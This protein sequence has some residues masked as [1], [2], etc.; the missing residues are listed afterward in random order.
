MKTI[1]VGGVAGGMSAATRLRRLDEHAEIVVF[2]RGSHVSYA[3]CGLPYYVGGVIPRRESLLL[4]TPESLAAR[5]RL[6][7]R[8]RH[9][10]IAI[11]PAA[12]TVT[13]CDLDR[14]AEFTESYDNLIL[15]LGASPFT[16]PL[17]GLDQALT[18]RDVGDVDRLAAATDSALAAGK[19]AVVIGA[20]FIGVEVAENLAHRGLEVTVV[21]LADQVLPPLDPEMAW[22][23]AEE[24]LRNGITLR[25][26]TQA[27]AIEQGCVRLSDGTSVATDLVLLSI[28]VRP[29]TGL[30][31]AAG[32]TIGSRG[33][34]VVDDAMRT[35]ADG[36]YAVGDMVEKSDL[37]T[38]TATLVPLANVANKQ[39]RRAADAIAGLPLSKGSAAALGTAVVKVFGLTAASTGASAKRL[40]AEGRQYVSVHIHP[41]HHAGYYPG[42]RQMHLKML[43]DPASGAIL[44]AQG[45]GAEGVERRIDVL[46]TAIAGRLT[47]PDLID[48][49][50]AYAPPYGSAK[51]PINMLGYLA[52]NILSGEQVVSWSEIGPGSDPQLGARHGLLI[53]VRTPQEFAKGSIP[54]AVNIPVDELRER[55][56]EIPP[57]HNTVFCQVGQRGHVASRMLAQ[58]GHDVANLS[59]G[60][61]TWSAGQQARALAGGRLPVR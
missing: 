1:I 38:G 33:G 7:V 14:C 23:I 48:L 58:L 34:V 44:G 28:G 31:R 17:P 42:A 55:H 49:E 3:N 43:M 51:D 32:I 5:F 61:L 60:W 8:V 4:Q 37:L 54:G 45:V 2:E 10:V 20:G 57:G 47:A 56:V 21:E 12:K 24:L 6:D 18:L 13:V 39:G 26:G 22:Y 16:P 59:G 11:D 15:S 41:A 9:E 50:L 53:D 46:A 25:L 40:R 30:A 36:V 27:T 35:S 52:D 29:E 19:R